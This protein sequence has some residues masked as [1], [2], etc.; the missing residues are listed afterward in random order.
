MA[1]FREVGGENG[2]LD[3]KYCRACIVFRRSHS[4]SCSLFIFEAV[5]KHPVVKKKNGGWRRDPRFRAKHLD[6][7]DKG[8]SVS[9]TKFPCGFTASQEPPTLSHGRPSIT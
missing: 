5:G 2:L 3:T 1:G 7:R 6:L 4:F 9:R 8:A